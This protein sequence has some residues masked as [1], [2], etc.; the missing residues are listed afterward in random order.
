MKETP[1]L[2]RLLKERGYLFLPLVAIILLLIR[3][4]N[5]LFSAFVGLLV[6][7]AVSFFRKESRIHIRKLLAALES[8]ALNALSVAVACAIVGVI[9]GVFTLTGAILSM[10]GAIVQLSGGILPLALLF[11]MLVRFFW[12]WACLRRPVMS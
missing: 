7:V 3:G 11:T 9:I 6:T 12:V 5:P 4:Y 1:K 10:A 2:W 8:G